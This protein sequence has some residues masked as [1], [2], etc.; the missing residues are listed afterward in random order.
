[1]SSSNVFTEVK[2]QPN[3]DGSGKGQM[4]A[5]KVRSRSV[6][7]PIFARSRVQCDRDGLTFTYSAL[8]LTQAGKIGE[9]Y[10]AQ[11][12]DYVN[13]AGSKNEPKKGPPEKKSEEQKTAETSGTG[14]A[15]KDKAGEAPNAKTGD[16][17][18]STSTNKKEAASATTNSKA[19]SASVTNKTTKARGRPKGSAA[20]NGTAAKK[21]KDKKKEP[22]QGTRVSTRIQDAEKKD[23]KR[24]AAGELKEQAPAKKARTT[25][26]KTKTAATKSATGTGAKRG[27]PASTAAKKTKAAV[28]KTKASGAAAGAK[29]RGRPAKAK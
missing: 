8:T 4:A 1:M 18:A 16:S 14:G 12:G 9:E 7:P 5:W 25:K 27:R 19:T 23:R 17:A 28:S 26:T 24:K 20:P 10:E 21:L 11:G 22:A 29:K 15:S 6:F 2:Q 3:K 13:E